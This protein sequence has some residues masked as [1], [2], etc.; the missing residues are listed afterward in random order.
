MNIYES[1]SNFNKA[2]KEFIWQEQLVELLHG[3][4]WNDGGCRSLMKACQIWLK[5]ENVQPYQIVKSKEKLHSEH[6]FIK[7]GN[8]YLDGDGLSTHKR[9]YQ[10]WRYDEGLSHVFIRPFNP[11]IEPD[12]SNGEEPFY[13]ERES[14]QLIATALQEAFDKKKF[15]KLTNKQSRTN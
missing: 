12:N 5:G 14:I 8:Y 4:G 10:R 15:V 2:Y 7:V 1:K 3:C 6:A 11:E 9:L 13:V